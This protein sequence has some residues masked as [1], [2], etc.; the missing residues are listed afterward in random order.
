VEVAAEV[1]ALKR[2]VGCDDNL[3]TASRPEN[4]AIVPDAERNESIALREVTA[5]VVDEREFAGSLV[6]GFDHAGSINF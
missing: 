2:E 3:M 6:L 5:N 1:P 4:G